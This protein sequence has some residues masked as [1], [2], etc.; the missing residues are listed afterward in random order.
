MDRRTKR[1]S[2]MDKT[3][4]ELRKDIDLLEKQI[5]GLVGGN[6]YSLSVTYLKNLV[7]KYEKITL[8]L[9]VFGFTLT[10]EGYTNPAGVKEDITERNAVDICNLLVTFKNDLTL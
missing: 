2:E 3:V 8:P 1:Y 7:G 10:E 4:I 9:G 6:K 5:S